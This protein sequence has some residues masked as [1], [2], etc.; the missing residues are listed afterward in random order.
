MIATL[1]A[2]VAMHAVGSTP[3]NAAIRALYSDPK[4]LAVVKRVNVAGSY[5]TVLT[6]GGRMEGDLV[7]DAI[8]VERF[9]F[10]WQPLELV[11]L[12]CRLDAHNFRRDALTALMRGMPQP[13]DDRPCGKQPRD[14][15]P[16]PEVE[17]VRQL[18]RGPLVPYVVVSEE[19]AM[20]EWYGGGG[21]QS[22]Y[23]KRSGKWQLVESGGGAMGVDYMQ[24]FGVPKSAWCAFGIYDA[25]CP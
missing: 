15:G 18:M 2:I 20:G 6:S 1:I 19:W 10:G 3:Q 8:L 11:N 9:S 16:A 21:G 5:A 12:Q 7:T 13:K 25:R 14:A 4:H 23:A 22:L 24:K 17:A